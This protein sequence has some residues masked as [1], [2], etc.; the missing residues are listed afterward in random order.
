M[1]VQPTETRTVFQGE[2]AVSDRPGTCFVTVLGSCVSACIYDPVRQI[3]GLNHFLLPDATGGNGNNLRY[4]VH[5]MELLIN[6]ILSA[7]AVRSRLEAKLFG[8]SRMLD[9]LQ[10]IGARNAE[11]ALGFLSNEKIPCKSQSLRGNCARRIRFWPQSGRAQQLLVRR[12]DIAEA[13]SIPTN[14]LK[15]RG[16]I[17]FF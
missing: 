17:E 7:G 16:D 6:G 4:G 12:S 11:F 10:D 3:G 14:R 2:F 15:S 5:S 8:G 1:T 13:R 9:D